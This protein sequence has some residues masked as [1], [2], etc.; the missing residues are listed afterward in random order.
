M[1]SPYGRHQLCEKMKI[2]SK[3]FYPILFNLHRNP[4]SEWLE[5]V[6]VLSGRKEAGR[7][8]GV[9]Q[10]VTILLDA[11][12]FDETVIKIPK[13][14]D[15]ISEGRFIINYED[16]ER[17]FSS[18]IGGK[19][20]DV[21][22][23]LKPSLTNHHGK[24]K[25][26]LEEYD[27][28]YQVSLLDEHCE[29]IEQLSS[30][31]S[32][33]S[34]GTDPS[35]PRV[36]EDLVDEPGQAAQFTLPGENLCCLPAGAQPTPSGVT[37][38]FL[39]GVCLSSGP[40]CSPISG[41][42][43]P[44]AGLAQPAG[45]PPPAP[46]AGLPA[47]GPPAG[48]PHP[49]PPVQGPPVGPPGPGPPGP[50]PPGPGPLGPGPPGPGPP[51]G[52]PGPGP[53][54]G[55]PGPGPPAGPPGPGP[56]LPGQAPGVILGPFGV[57]VLGAGTD[58]LRTGRAGNDRHGN[59]LVA[60][61]TNL[62]AA[63]NLTHREIRHALLNGPPVAAG[64]IPY[65]NMS[66]WPTYI[67]HVMLP[68]L[69]HPL[70]YKIYFGVDVQQFYYF[71]ANYV[72]PF[73]ANRRIVTGTADSMTA[74]FFLKFRQDIP[75]RYLGLLFGDAEHKTIS[76]WFDDILDSVYQT[77]PLLVRSRNLS[78]P[79]NLRDLLEDMHSASVRNTRFSASFT[80]TMNEV[81]RRN[82]L[83]GH[84]HLVG[85]M[86]DSRTILI[87]KSQDF[88]QQRREYSTKIKSNGIIKIAASG[89]DGKQKFQYLTTNSISPAC[90]DEAMS[91]FL[92]DLE[93]T[94]GNV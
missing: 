71:R 16:S 87:P 59:Q 34:S 47:P 88:D 90:S 20:L 13:C 43:A 28:F 93:T 40:G 51:A 74:M 32:N 58:A 82:P 23:F 84:L 2:C 78:N 65:P 57:G 80:P 15:I 29:E 27:K 41:P 39:P 52:P 17:L 72:E 44:H 66:F 81:M 30:Q 75:Y 94:Q 53:P 3:G 50:G 7:I 21:S 49:G 77:S 33:L 64:Q 46:P 38:P 91:S 5:D 76:S 63:P 14:A 22:K 70:K 45:G 6:A 18:S 10:M 48:P 24:K 1:E 60:I 83:L 55:P 86:W 85:C 4:E 61:R 42:P 69:I 37:T 73:L 79:N 92:I 62:Q 35:Q 9:E 54:A 8:D 26:W 68:S 25:I 11:I 56:P 12:S 36:E 31:M 19:Q 67:N 89:L